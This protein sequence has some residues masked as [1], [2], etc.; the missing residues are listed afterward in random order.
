MLGMCATSLLFFYRVRAVYG[1]SKAVTAIFGFLWAVTFGLSF[2]DPLSID[3]DVS[4]CT[5]T[6][7]R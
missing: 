3:G 5:S 4:T 1:N 6:L 7:A 2:V